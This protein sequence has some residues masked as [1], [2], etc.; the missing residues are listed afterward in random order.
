MVSRM[1]AIFEHRSG[2]YLMYASTGAQE[3]A[4]RRPPERLLG[5]SLVVYMDD[6]LMNLPLMLPAWIPGWVVLILALPVLLY[7]LA[8][9]LMP[10][11]VFGVQARIESLEA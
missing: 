8:F 11:S 7:V 9:L 5:R 4:L 6:M 3:I 2:A 10:F 1:R